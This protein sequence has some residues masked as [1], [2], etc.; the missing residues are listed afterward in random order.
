M[1][2]HLKPKRPFVPTQWVI[3]VQCV[4]AGAPDQRCETVVHLYTCT[5]VQLYSCTFVELYTCT[6][7]Q[8]YIC[9]LVQLYSCTLVRNSV[10][11]VSISGNSSLH[12]ACVR[13]HFAALSD[14][15][16]QSLVHTPL[17]PLTVLSVQATSSPSV[18]KR[19]KTN[20]KPKHS[21]T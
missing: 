1:Y 11:K 13:T 2:T 5:L 16:L 20:A 4:K 10:H 17:R 19:Y 15:V 12:P 18:S 7:V 6:L 8:L 3:A 21:A 9:T 14:Q